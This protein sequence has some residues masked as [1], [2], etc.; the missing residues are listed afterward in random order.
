MDG[1]DIIIILIITSLV[2]GMRR[3]LTDGYEVPAPPTAPVM[4]TPLMPPPPTTTPVPV[5]TSS[6]IGKVFETQNFAKLTE[7]ELERHK[8]LR[9]LNKTRT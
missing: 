9:Q 8:F 7:K 3:R 2:I 1:A 6:E 5:V 4:T